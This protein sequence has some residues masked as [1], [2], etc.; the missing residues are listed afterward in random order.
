MTKPKT[1][2]RKEIATLIEEMTG[3]P[4]SVSQV[5]DNEERWGMKAART[6]DLNKRFI[7]YFREKVIS[8][9]QSRFLAK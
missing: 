5:R 7:R 3:C 1:I 6:P 8:A 9:I 4:V 2:S